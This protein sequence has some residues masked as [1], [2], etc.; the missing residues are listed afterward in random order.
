M[1]RTRRGSAPSKSSGI[2]VDFAD[3]QGRVLM[4]EGDYLAKVEKVEQKTSDNSG[5]DYLAWTFRTID[6][7]KK[8]NNKPLYVNTSLQPQ[9]LWNLRNLL[10]A[11][12]VDVPDSEMELQLE[13]YIDLECVLTVEDDEYEGRKTSR[14][15]D[16]M[17]VDGDGKKEEK[18]EEKEEKG[19]RPSSRRG[20]SSSERSSRSSGLSGRS[21]SK[22]DEPEL[23]EA[24]DVRNMDEDQLGE[25]IEEHELDV[26][27]DDF[28]TLRRKVNAVIDALEAA[29]LLAAE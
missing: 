24:A 8:Y 3:T 22:K 23:I 11:L 28:S 13:E 14:V 7:D 1:P 18:D 6:D 21:S 25:L 26:N 29:E 2:K 5:N 12:G 10:E 4:A 16:Y 27:L 15:V 9:A 19:E 17:P 20:G